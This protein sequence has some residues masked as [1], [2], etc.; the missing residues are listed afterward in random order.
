MAKSTGKPATIPILEKSHKNDIFK[1]IE[2]AGLQ[3]KDFKL[4][5]TKGVVRVK[6]K[7]SK[8]CFTVSSGPGPYVGRY[9]FTNELERPYD[10]HSSAGLLTHV[11][12]WLDLV[13]HDINT[14]DLWAEL[15]RE[16]KFL[17]AVFDE[18]TENTPFTREEQRE[19]AERLKQLPTDFKRMYSLSSAQI[20]QLEIKVDYLTKAAKR[21]G[22]KD[23]RILFIGAILATFF[24]A[25]LPPETIHGIIQT[26]FRAIGLL[27]TPVPFLE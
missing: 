8:F 20:E 9:N 26:S 7:W 5:N 25:A 27:S 15:Q 13:K 17:E 4:I 1:A 3:P 2:A 10:A 24:T 16:N 14:P 23:W 21:M 12:N 19:I 18:A 22:R 6:H 11:K